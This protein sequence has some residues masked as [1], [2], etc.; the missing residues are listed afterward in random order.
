MG[1][2]PNALVR[3]RIRLRTRVRVG[4]MVRVGSRVRT[5]RFGTFRS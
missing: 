1:L 4:S 2:G 3:V 5:H